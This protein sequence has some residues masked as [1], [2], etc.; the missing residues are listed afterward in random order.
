MRYLTIILFLVFILL[1]SCEN[2]ITKKEIIG[3]YAYNNCQDTII[4]KPDHTYIHFHDYPTNEGN[5]Y[6]GNWKLDSVENEILFYEF[7][8]FCEPEAL[9]TPKGIWI[10]R[11][12]SKKG[13]IKL[14][15]ASDLNAYYM[16]IE[17]NNIKNA[18]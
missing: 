8:N 18:H 13:I 4:I 15:Y 16:K 2:R 17:K 10:S 5:T 6:T 1:I 12:I 14:M 3:V 9:N 11:I 7:D